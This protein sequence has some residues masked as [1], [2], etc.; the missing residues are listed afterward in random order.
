MKKQF[1]D[2]TGQT[3]LVMGASSGI[4][5]QSAILLSELGARCVLVA[6]REKELKEAVASLSGDGHLYVPADLSELENIKYLLEKIRNLAGRLQG[7][8]Y[9]AG[10]GP[11]RPYSIS[12][13]QFMREVMEINFFAF[14]ETVRQFVKRKNSEDGAKIVAI[15]SF[16]GARPEKGQAAYGAS[17]AAM[18]AAIFCLAQELMP[19]HISVNGVRPAIV[20]TD[21]AKNSKDG[22]DG[23]AKQPLGVIEPEEIAKLIGYL[24]SPLANKIT[25]RLFDIDAGRQFLN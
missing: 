20:D 21:M 9:C 7:L 15:S 22:K 1:I 10:I 11:I 25:G 17:K 23:L 6:R 18:D 16:A 2:L 4:G 5:R 8:I 19:R 3:V 12:D 24:V 13:P 14:Y